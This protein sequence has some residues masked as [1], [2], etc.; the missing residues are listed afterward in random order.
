MKSILKYYIGYFETPNQNGQIA[1]LDYELGP[2]DPGEMYSTISIKPKSIFIEAQRRQVSSQV[3][4][5]QIK[6]LESLEID[7]FGIINSVLENEMDMGMEK[8]ILNLMQEEAER[9]MRKQWTRFQIFANKFFGYEPK[10]VWKTHRDLF[11]ILMLSSIK[12]M[13]QTRMGGKSFIITNS[14]IAAEIQDSSEFEFSTEGNIF[15]LKSGGIY[16][17]GNLGPIE[18]LVNPSWPFSDCRILMGIKPSSPENSRIFMMEIPEGEFLKVED[19]IMPERMKIQLSK[20][21]GIRS[22]P[23]ENYLEIKI[24]DQGRRHNLFTHLMSKVFK[25]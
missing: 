24:A 25:K 19:P 15:G 10:K 23:S 21:Y 9:N 17:V 14:R 3:T 18:V 4:R 8:D 6:D 20:R 2:F 12:M 13:S 7:S 16:F 22:I 1:Y 11:R 5:E